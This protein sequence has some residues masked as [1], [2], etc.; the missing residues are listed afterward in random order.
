MGR[1]FREIPVFTYGLDQEAHELSDCMEELKLIHEE[2]GDN[3]GYSVFAQIFGDTES[4]SRFYLTGQILTPDKSR[5]IRDI[6]TEDGN[7]V[8][9][10]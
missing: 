3:H 4:K 8:D 6:L 1:I 2:L 5:R 9:A 7:A 10:P